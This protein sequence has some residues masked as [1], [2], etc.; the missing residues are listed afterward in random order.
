[1]KVILNIPIFMSYLFMVMKGWYIDDGNMVKIYI[2]IFRLI[3][4]S[5]VYVKL[6]YCYKIKVQLDVLIY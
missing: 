4:G 2:I 6:I 3:N 1:M 5:I